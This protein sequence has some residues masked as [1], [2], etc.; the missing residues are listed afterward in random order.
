VVSNTTPYGLDADALNAFEGS[1][2]NLNGRGRSLVI[3]PHPGEMSRLTG[4]NVSDIQSNRVNV[5]KNFAWE[6]ALV[7]VLK[8]HRTVIASPEGEIWVNATGNPG[9]ATGGTGDVLTG[10]VAGLI[11]QHPRSVRSNYTRGISAWIN[12]DALAPN[13]ERIPLAAT[14]LIRFL[15]KLS[16]ARKWRLRRAASRLKNKNKE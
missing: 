10:I 6:H 12:G 8:G 2:S 13:W 16:E 7:V 9:M 3:T 4:L 1:S 14:D 5:A 15:P 11:A